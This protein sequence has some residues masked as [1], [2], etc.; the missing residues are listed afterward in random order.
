[1][2]KSFMYGERERLWNVNVNSF[3]G[4][5][6]KVCFFNVHANE[7]QVFHQLSFPIKGTGG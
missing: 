3:V 5:F 6:V 7:R 2:L 4:N 1:M